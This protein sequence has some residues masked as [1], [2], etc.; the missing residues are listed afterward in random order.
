MLESFR[1]ENKNKDEF[2][3]VF[4]VLIHTGS[5]PGH[6]TQI[7]NWLSAAAMGDNEKMV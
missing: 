6:V 4:L 5:C 3:L 7:G 2:E 1:S